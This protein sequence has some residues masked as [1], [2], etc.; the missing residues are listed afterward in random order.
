[1]ELVID[2]D[3]ITA[4]HPGALD[5]FNKAFIAEIEKQAQLNLVNTAR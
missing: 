2:G 3:L 1:M 5:I 4:K